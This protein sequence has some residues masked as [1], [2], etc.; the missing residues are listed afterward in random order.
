MK[1]KKTKTKKPIEMVIRKMNG[2]A[3]DLVCKQV[4]R[5]FHIRYAVDTFSDNPWEMDEFDSRK[6]GDKAH[7]ATTTHPAVERAIEEAFLTV[8][9][10]VNYPELLK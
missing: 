9:D 3:Y 10:Y 4:C 2:M 8:E 7:L 6:K 5:D 1:K